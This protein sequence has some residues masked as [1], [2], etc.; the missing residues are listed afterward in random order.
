VLHSLPSPSSPSFHPLFLLFPSTAASF[1]APV[2]LEF[3]LALPVSMEAFYLLSLLTSQLT[4]ATSFIHRVFR[5]VWIG[6]QVEFFEVRSTLLSQIQH[7]T[8]LSIMVFQRLLPPSTPATIPSD[9][10]AT[11]RSFD[12]PV[13]E[14]HSLMRGG[15]VPPPILPPPLLLA[16]C[17]SSRCLGQ[18]EVIQC[19]RVVFMH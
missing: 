15:C 6:S 7:D 2:L 17:G 3:S 4:P 19:W 14:S 8:R 1:E 12:V 10:P 16:N 13:S 18:R 5:R 9:L 11:E